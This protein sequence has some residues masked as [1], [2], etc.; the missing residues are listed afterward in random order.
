[1][2]VEGVKEENLGKFVTPKN[3]LKDRLSQISALIFDWDGVFNS[4]EK[5]IRQREIRRSYN[6]L[7]II[8]TNE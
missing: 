2:D 7:K 6:S 4:G 5:V 1:M 8:S 3:E